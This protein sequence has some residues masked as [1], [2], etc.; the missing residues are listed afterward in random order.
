[1]AWTEEQKRA[2]NLEG[3]NILVS[4]GAGS[5]KTAVLTERVKRKLLS[6]V[7]INELLILTFTNAAAAEMKER[8]RKNILKTPE[9]KD[10][11]DY[12]DSAFIMT[13]DAFSLYVVKKYHT[14]LN[15]TSD[16]GVCDNIL[17]ERKK[18]EILE[19][20]LNDY[21]ENPSKDFS[22][23]IDHFCLKDDETLKNY[24]LNIY[25][26][27]ELKYDKN[28]YLDNYI[29]SFYDHDNIISF[30]DD[31]IS[32]LLLKQEEMRSLLTEISIYADG[33]FVGKLEDNFSKL[34]SATSYEEFALGCSF[35]SITVPRGSDEEL[36]KKKKRLF[37]IASE[38][39]DYCTYESVEEIEDEI[40]A[41]KDDAFC[42]ISI[43]R[44]F[45]NRLEDYKN[46]NAFYSFSDISRLAIRV[47][48]DNSDVLNEL[49][50]HFQEIMV[51]EY[52]DTSDIQE[53]F[54]SLISHN[55]VYMVGDIKQS[56][57]R[58]RNAN[59]SIFKEKYDLYQD[60]S[61][62]EVIDL[63]KNFRSRGEVLD[64]INLIFD[65]FM[66]KE[67]GGADYKKSHRMIFGNTSYIEEGK[68]N[69]NYDLDVITYNKDDLGDITSSEEE[70]FIIGR[71]I[72]DKI[73]SMYLVFDKDD[74]I[75]RPI[76]YR[77]FVILLDKSR[78]FELYKKIF[79]Y[80]HIPLVILRDESLSEQ[81]DLLVLRNL[82]RFILCIKEKRYDVEFRYTFTS[83]CRSFLW[84]K[85]DAEIY[86]YFINN[87]YLESDL[88]LKCLRLVPLLN[89]VSLSSF[90]YTL[91]EEFNYD[92]KLFSLG[93]VKKG[94]IREEYLYQFCLNYERMGYGIND[95][96]E[97]LND[98]YEK[99]Y[100]LRFQMNISNGDCVQIMT[101]HKS[102]GL[103]FPVCYFAGF[104]SRFNMS[105]LN[106]RILYDFKY[107]IILP[108]VDYYYKD[109]ILKMLAKKMVRKE[110]IS[111]RIRLLYVAFTRAKEKVIIVM[112]ELEEEEETSIVPNYLKEEYNSFLTIMKSIYT[113]ILPYIRKSN[114]IGTKDYL[115][116]I[117]EGDNKLVKV[118]DK[119][120]VDEVNIS[121]DYLDK[122]HYSK[123]KMAPRT[124]EEMDLMEMGTRMHEVL[125]EI[126]FSNYQLD[127]YNIS[128]FMKDKIVAFI[129]S[130]LIK[131]NI[132]YPMYKEY[133]F[134]DLDLDS[135]SHGIIDLLIDGEEV[136][137]I[138]YKLKNIMDEA[139]QKQLNGYRSYISKKTD[140]NIR[141]FLYS[142]LDEK[143]VEV[144]V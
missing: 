66:D 131:N 47:V 126:D 21:Y 119:L 133:E 12:I 124:K 33:D 16:I 56:I 51:D 87:N 52:Q 40:M 20:V 76:E 41:T 100:D 123:E 37:Q 17:L 4:A 125:E 48:Q 67:Y 110:E 74:K 42:I 31:F 38:I 141:C 60:K 130:D 114:V 137:I 78:D 127:E 102:K 136:F 116:E 129:N 92:E 99:G 18:R 86:N 24:L 68:T 9:I 122:H 111:E 32:Y 36:K 35:N 113:T 104:A 120:V 19:E 96:V 27:I 13:F 79:Q 75:L 46:K 71:D 6:G 77:D 28:K 142:L 108:K 50:N 3:K 2:I 1:M 132:N 64:S 10:E 105:E 15:I 98:V 63:L 34:L 8:I 93:D 43:L 82:L 65:C 73:N 30:I 58:F 26:K 11:A 22:N 62:G 101:I 44:D 29:D 57:Y 107:G 59:P 53:M 140:K 45:D 69:Q 54:I 89:S 106:E 118:D 97:Y 95:F 103:E 84:K 55:N 117:K 70:A 112:P 138:D 135:S 7:H 143:F 39:K 91:L 139:Y 85:T 81:D 90:F 25:Q 109:T 5:G 144:T 14:K 23:L 49:K 134:I 121:Y 72:Q 128:P 61:L 80:L 115:K 83:I 88:Y 94:R